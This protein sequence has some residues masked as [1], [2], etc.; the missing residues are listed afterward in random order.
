MGRT[1]TRK[2]CFLCFFSGQ[3]SLH[4]QAIALRPELWRAVPRRLASHRH[5]RRDIYN[6]LRSHVVDTAT[7][8]SSEMLFGS[9][10]E[11][12]GTQH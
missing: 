3:I 8:V 11:Q 6:E 7:A 5:G 12:T 10:I 9:G 2:F 4:P 1:E